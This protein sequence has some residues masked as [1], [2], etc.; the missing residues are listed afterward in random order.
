MKQIARVLGAV[1]DG[2]NTT[3]DVADVTGLPIRTCSSVVHELVRLGTL[4]HV[5]KIR[6]IGRPLKVFEIAE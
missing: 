5:G 1:I 6:G 4:K 2:C 3:R